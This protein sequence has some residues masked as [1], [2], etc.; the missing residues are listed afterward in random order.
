MKF[1]LN[2]VFSRKMILIACLLLIT[3][4]ATF[5]AQAFRQHK[6]VSSSD[7]SQLP[8]IDVDTMV[9]A[10]IQPFKKGYEV[11]GVI[12]AVDK[13]GVANLRQVNLFESAGQI[14]FY[15]NHSSSIGTK[16]LHGDVSALIVSPDGKYAVEFI[17]GVQVN[18]SRRVDGHEQ[19]ALDPRAINFYQRIATSDK[20]DRIERISTE[21]HNGHWLKVGTTTNDCLG[22]KC[23]V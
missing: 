13:D 17:G 6:S 18:M 5:N 10:Y 11:Q 14:G 2:N 21:W 16:L 20:Q 7:M 9:S 19:Y 23:I 8:K 1:L 15:L 22:P 4:L 12:A 3:T